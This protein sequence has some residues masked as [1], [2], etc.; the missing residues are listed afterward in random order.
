MKTKLN[1]VAVAALLAAMAG[2][3]G[4]QTTVGTGATAQ[5]GVA[6]GA[7]ATQGDV[8]YD[9]S[10][11]S[12]AGKTFTKGIAIGQGTSAAGNDIVIGSGLSAPFDGTGVSKF[13]IGGMQ[14]DGQLVMRR[15]VGVSSGLFANDGANMQNVWDAR[16]LAIST[17]NAY[18]DMSLM[19]VNFRLGNVETVT[20]NNTT[21]LDQHDVILANHDQRITTAQTTADTALTVATG[22]DTKATVA[23]TQ[24]SQALATANQA[25][26][27]VAAVSS[28]V[29][30]LEGKVDEVRKDSFR[31]TASAMAMAGATP[32][33][34]P[35][36]RAWYLRSGIYGGATAI[37]GGIAMSASSGVTGDVKASYDGK[38]VGLSF[39]ISNKF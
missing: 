6:I 17:S 33:L 2:T 20:A 8:T 31:G 26:Q 24:S 32:A 21:R 27:E 5:S 3:A 39:G 35:G 19:P 11:G 9:S 7:G 38:R 36:E 22:A 23:L 25:R 14:S 16:A 30:A 18:T 4:A 37:S 28:R 10:Y 13:V 29:D 34:N 15:I 12:L 1:I